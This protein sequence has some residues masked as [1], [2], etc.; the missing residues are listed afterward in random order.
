VLAR[1][2]MEAIAWLAKSRRGDPTASGMAEADAR[3]AAIRIFVGAF[4]YGSG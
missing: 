1:G 4:D 3:A 2:A